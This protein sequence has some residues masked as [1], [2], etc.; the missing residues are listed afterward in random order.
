MGVQKPEVHLRKSIFEFQFECVFH[1]VGPITRDSPIDC[2]MTFLA[3]YI[4]S[5]IPVFVAMLLTCSS[6]L[7]GLLAAAKAPLSPCRSSCTMDQKKSWWTLLRESLVDLTPTPQLRK[8]HALLFRCLHLMQQVAEETVNRTREPVFLLQNKA[9]FTIF[10][11][12]IL[13]KFNIVCVA[14]KTA[15]L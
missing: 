10:K 13:D 9:L 6:P 5:K 4:W 11:E 8:H 1:R 15:A 7:A 14:F 3:F 2:L 12:D